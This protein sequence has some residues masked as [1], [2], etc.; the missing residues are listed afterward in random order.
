MDCLVLGV[1]AA[2]DAILTFMVGGKPEEFE[3]AKELLQCMGKNVVN[4]G[5]VGTGQVGWLYSGLSCL[6]CECCEGRY[7]DLHGY[8]IG[9]CIHDGLHIGDKAKIIKVHGNQERTST[10]YFIFDYFYISRRPR[11]ATI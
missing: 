8:N 7:T 2:R 5:P 3:A 11:Y 10:S 4:T 1:N 9:I 6:R